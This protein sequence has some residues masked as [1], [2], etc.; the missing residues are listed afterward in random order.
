M[1]SLDSLHC[2]EGADNRSPHLEDQ[3]RPPGGAE[4]GIKRR[5]LWAQPWPGGRVRGLRRNRLPFSSP[6]PVPS[7]SEELCLPTW[8]PQGTPDEGGRWVGGQTFRADYAHWVLGAQRQL[9]C[10]LV[11][12]EGLRGLPADWPCTWSR[13]M[14]LMPK[15]QLLCAP[16]LNQ[17]SETEFWVK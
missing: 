8:E 12:G 5:R 4:P 1:G 6:C 15:T 17:I 7:P 14:K 11:L 16:L 9:S 10:Q 3:W 13:M 2:C